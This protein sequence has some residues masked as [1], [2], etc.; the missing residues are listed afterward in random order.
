M[1]PTKYWN[2]APRRTTLAAAPDPNPAAMPFLMSC[3]CG[4]ASSLENSRTVNGS[5]PNAATVRKFKIASEAR[6][7]ASTRD[8][9]AR[10]ANFPT[11]FLCTMMGTAMAGTTAN[12]TRV[13]CHEAVKATPRPATSTT[14]CAS[15]RE[16][17][18]PVSALTR[19]QSCDSWL[20]SDPAVRS[21]ETSNQPMFCR[22]MDVN[23]SSRTRIDKRSEMTAKQ[24][25]RTTALTETTNPTPR[26][27]SAQ[28]SAFCR[29]SSTSGLKKTTMNSA[30]RN[31]IA[32]MVR[33]VTREP[34]R[35]PTMWNFSGFISF[36]I[37]PTDGEGSLVALVPLALSAPASSAPSAE[38]V[39]AAVVLSCSAPSL[40]VVLSCSAL[41]CCIPSSLAS[42]LSFCNCASTRA[43]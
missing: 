27:T 28:N 37:Q 26:K 3:C 5:R 34:S 21:G 42:T 20:A 15:A 8:F 17:R 40:S 29:M 30:I 35:P 19:K 2:D 16:T 4:K 23:A 24:Y 33:P 39:C 6:L 43:R 1:P 7:P 38:L 18:S 13:S 9:V 31:P 14:I 36:Q 41:S 12:T 25:W 10:S 32:G 11:I 22:M